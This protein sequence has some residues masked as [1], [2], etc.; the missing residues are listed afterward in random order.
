LNR[1]RFALKK[2]AKK[3]QNWIVVNPKEFD[4]KSLSE[5][6]RI[7]ARSNNLEDVLIY[8]RGKGYSK[9][10]SMAMLSELQNIDL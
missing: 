5:C 8:L 2:Q 4:P 9:G 7:L 10:W 1:I 3:N 6:E